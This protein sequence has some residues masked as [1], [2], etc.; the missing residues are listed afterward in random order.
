MAAIRVEHENQDRTLQAQKA[1]LDIVVVDISQLRILG[2]HDVA[3]D[4]TPAPETQLGDE[5]VE[6]DGTASVRTREESGELRE[7]GDSSG[8]PSKKPTTEGHDSEDEVPLSKTTLNPAARSFMPTSRTNTPLTPVLRGTP[9]Q[10]TPTIRDE[11]DIEMGEIEDPK[12][13]KVKKKAREE[14]LEEGEASD[15]SSELSE[16]PD[17]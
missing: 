13:P 14:E 10:H 5:D 17:D 9:S 1:A 4:S 6:M 11:D 7:D 12:D 15:Q 2:K 3:E 8:H 16:P